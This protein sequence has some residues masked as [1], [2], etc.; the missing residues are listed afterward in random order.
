MVGTASYLNV[1]MPIIDCKNCGVKQVNALWA[2]SGSRVALL[3]ELF[4]NQPARLLPASVIYP[5]DVDGNQGLEINQALNG[6]EGRRAADEIG[7]HNSKPH[8]FR[9]TDM[10]GEGSAQSDD[11][12]YASDEEKLTDLHANVEK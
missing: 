8:Y 7:W 12:E 6:P 1:G 11:G 5:G 4:A 3:I 10:T 9:H 2:R